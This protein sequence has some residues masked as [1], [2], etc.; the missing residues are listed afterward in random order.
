[1]SAM[2]AMSTTSGFVSV[3]HQAVVSFAYD[4]GWYSAHKRCCLRNPSQRRCCLH[5]PTINRVFALK[6]LVHAQVLVSTPQKN[7]TLGDLKS[8][9]YAI[10]DTQSVGVLR[11]VGCNLFSSRCC[12]DCTDISDM[13]LV[14][15]S[16]HRLPSSWSK[17]VYV[18]LH[19]TQSCL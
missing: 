9:F 14:T 6:Q 8:L 16:L 11:L 2:S 5:D 10:G 7:Y 13:H 3:C 12:S 17:H 1:M 18:V 4:E 15:Q 19:V